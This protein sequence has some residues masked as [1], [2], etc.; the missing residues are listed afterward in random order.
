[1]NRLAVLLLLCVSLSSCGLFRSVTKNKDVS[2]ARTVVETDSSEKMESK[3]IDRGSTVS[4]DQSLTVT[5]RE[6]KRTTTKPGSDVSFRADL[7][8]LKN[9][10]TIT[11]DSAGAKFSVWLDKISQTLH[12]GM[13]T[14]A[15]ETNEEISERITSQNDLSSEDNRDTEETTSQEVAVSSSQESQSKSKTK[16]VEKEGKNA[17]WFVVLIS[18][19]VLIVVYFIYRRTKIK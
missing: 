19:I 18:I 16:D 14:P 11:M 6:I 10:E 13:T 4:T 3:K 17:V 1:M 5:E 15:E 2:E 8:R 12:F 9:G 7:L